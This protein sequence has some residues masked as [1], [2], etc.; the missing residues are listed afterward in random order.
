VSGFNVHASVSVGPRERARLERLCRYLLRPPLALERL[1]QHPS[2]KLRYSLKKPWSDGSIAVLL[3]P[4]DLLSRLCALVPPPR[5]H[6]LRYFGVLS[7]HAS[8]RREVVPNVGEGAPTATGGG[9][10]LALFQG[11]SLGDDVQTRRKPW[12]WLLRHVFQVDVSTCR[13]CGRSMRLL[14][15]ATTPQAVARLLVKHGLGPRPPPPAWQPPPGQ[16]AFG[17]VNDG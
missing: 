13:A 3:E 12:A 9:K 6:M 4:E 10:Q 17:F 11:E 16:L 5:F 15:T 8:R 2:G 14:E 7:S 1:E